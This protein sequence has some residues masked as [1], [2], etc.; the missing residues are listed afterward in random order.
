[1]FH[2]AAESD[3][4][5]RVIAAN[6][7]P[8]LI[9]FI[10]GAGGTGILIAKAQM[11]ADE[12]ANCLNPAPAARSRPE[13][14]PGDVGKLI[15]F[16]IAA[17]ERKN[18]RLVRQPLDR[19]LFGIELD[20]VG[21]AAVLDDGVTANREIARWRDKPA[22]TIAKCVKINVRRNRGRGLERRL[23]PNIWR[24]IAMRVKQANH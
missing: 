16:A 7:H 6:A 15:G 22:D 2:A 24:M 11:V 21:P 5:M 3:G 14:L 10:G 13:Q 4:E 18:Q 19:D 8:L 1:M 20:W 12:I 23:E 9:G 17:A